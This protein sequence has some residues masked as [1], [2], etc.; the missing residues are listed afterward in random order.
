MDPVR[1]IADTVLYEGYLLWPYRRSALK[2]R[3]RW[4][5]GGVY[6]RAYAE[7][8]GDRWTVSSEVL[9]ETAPGAD[10]EV[11]LRFLHAVRRQAMSGDAPVDEVA[12][13]GE[14]YTT[15]QEAREREITS[16]RLR[17]ARLLRSPVRVPVAVAAGAEEEPIGP[18]GASDAWFVRMWER[19]DGMMEVSAAEVAPGVVR[20]RAEVVNTAALGTETMGGG[21]DGGRRDEAVDAGMLC[22]HL[23]AS[24][25]AGAFASSTDPPGRLAAAAAT[26]RNEG[27]WPVLVGEPG[28]R[29]TVLAAPI[30]LYDWPRVSPESPG[31]LFDGSEIDRLLIASV[32]G[33]A[34][35]ERR[36]MASTDPR[37]KEILDRCAA[38]TSDELLALHGTMRDPRTDA[39]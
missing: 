39:W 25:T 20:L 35:D 6:P 17:V 14:T 31:D 36:E 10:V 7:R 9:L 4:T 22:A 16:G 21:A 2:N 24:T 3:R 11:T 38:L 32:L 12:V 13:G 19:L 33:L 15:W 23:V 28:S 30:V 18:P 1:T 5:I 8:E 29:H 27:L 34:E 37:A 26:C